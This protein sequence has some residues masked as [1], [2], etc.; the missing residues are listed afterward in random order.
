MVVAVL[1]AALELV[2]FT[3]F[4]FGPLALAAVV[5]AI[6]AAVGGGVEL[7]LAAFLG[8]GIAAMFALRPIARRHLD[9]DP[10]LVTNVDALIGKH[11]RVLEELTEDGF[12]LIRFDGDNWTARP[13]PGLGAIAPDTQVEIVRIAGATAIVKPIDT[14]DPGAEA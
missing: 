12:G 10:E 2:V 1:L 11:A 7:Q 5:S 14:P 3:G 8:L 13:Q 6:I 4:I 9:K